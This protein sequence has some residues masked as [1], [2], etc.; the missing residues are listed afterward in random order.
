[1]SKD[2]SSGR[3]GADEVYFVLSWSQLSTSTSEVKS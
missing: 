2:G 1:M 3:E